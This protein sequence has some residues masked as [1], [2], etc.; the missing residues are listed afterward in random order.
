ML[1]VDPYHF[2]V[3]IFSY[4]NLA[5]GHRWMESDQAEK[6][7]NWHKFYASKLTLS[8]SLLQTITMF[9]RKQLE[10]L[11]YYYLLFITITILFPIFLLVVDWAS[12]SNHGPSSALAVYAFALRPNGHIVSQAVADEEIDSEGSDIEGR[13]DAGYESEEDAETAEEKRLRLARLYL[14]V[15]CLL[16]SRKWMDG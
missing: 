2:V 14:Q 13:P 3:L 11:P 1:S 9:L 16:A 7:D 15:T 12:W 4:M 10:L 5:V 6:T 8:S